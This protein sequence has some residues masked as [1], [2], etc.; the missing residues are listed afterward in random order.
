MSR[1]INV[2]SPYYLK[3][4]EDDLYSVDLDIYV[5][6]G[7]S[8]DVTD[9][10]YSFSKISVAG[11]QYVVFELAEYI[12]DYLVTEYGSY[13]TKNVWFKAE[14]QVKD[15]NGDDVGSL[16]ST[17]PEIAFDGYSYFEEG[18]NAELSRQLL[19]SNN[20]I[21]FKC[22]EDII[23]P[24]FAE[25]LSTITL[26]INDYADVFWES[27]DFFWEKYNV[28]WS[29][30]AT[31]PIVITDNGNS[32]Q[33]IQYIIITGTDNF[34][35]SDFI[36]ITSGIQ[37]GGSTI[38]KLKKITELKYDPLNVIFYNKFGALQN[39]WFFKRSFTTINTSADTYKANIMDFSAQPSY[40]TSFAQ[41]QT[42]SKSGRETITCNTGFID[43]AYNDVIRQLMLSEQV[44]IDNGT[45]VL[46]VIVKTDSLRFKTGV[47]DKLMDYSIDFEYAF[48][49]IN[50]IR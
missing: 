5:W 17:T 21:Q 39:I 7:L 16:Q 48:D 15:I 19:Q 41:Y 44:W 18:A 35:D 4:Q 13:S 9:P 27:A 12:K 10:V 37:G 50:N 36:T 2:R 46:P 6:E 42:F 49:K 33:K 29:E 28:S 25:D 32:N 20:V 3:V 26:S 45:S 47:A 11:N 8:D 43:E 30:Y 14:Y 40:N 31:N 22:G 24:I 23:I 34:E 38:I 1:K